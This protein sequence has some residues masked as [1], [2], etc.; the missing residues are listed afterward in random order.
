MDVEQFYG[1]DFEVRILHQPQNNL[2][3][4]TTFRTR[5]A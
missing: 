5:R 1:D 2:H 4:Y 3:P